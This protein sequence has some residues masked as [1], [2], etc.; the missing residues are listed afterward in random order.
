MY[1]CKT[2]GNT[3]VI[4]IEYDYGSP[5]RYDGVSEWFCNFCDSRYGRWSGKKLEK[6]EEELRFGYVKPRGAI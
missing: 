5:N 6:G 4:G 3:N 1:E 2:C